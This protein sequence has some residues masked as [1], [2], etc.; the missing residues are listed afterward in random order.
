MKPLDLEFAIIRKVEV[1][2]VKATILIARDSF[3][4]ENYSGLG[5]VG[6]VQGLKTNRSEQLQ[7]A[8]LEEP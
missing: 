1:E 2:A 7:K 4:R 5:L 8:F 3:E 6:F